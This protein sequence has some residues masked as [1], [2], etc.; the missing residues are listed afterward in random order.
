MLVNTSQLDEITDEALKEKEK[1]IKVYARV[2]PEQK[3]RIVKTLQQ[4]GEFVAMTGDGVND[5]PALQS[6]DIGIAMGIT[7]TDVSK[8]AADMILLDDNFSTIVKAVKEGRHIFDNIR[9]FIRY[10]MTGNAG[11]V[12]TIFLAPFFGLPVPLLPIHILWVNLVTDGLPGLTF[13]AEKSEKGIM[14]RPPRPTTESIFANGMGWQILWAG[15]LMGIVCIITQI[16][17]ME[18]NSSHAQT[19]VFTVLCF[20][21]LGNAM[22]VRSE[23]E[24]VFTLGPMSNRLMFYA[25]AITVGL[26]LAIIYVPFLNKIFKTQP[27][28]LNE[29]IITILLSSVIFIAIEIEKLIR[30]WKKL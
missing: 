21:Q 10:V 25:L 9:K 4:Q 14:Q 15:F 7:G 8:E 2:T 11:E 20:S 24:S 1:H 19:M 18:N 6:A 30:R 16:I 29:L 22:A 27:L 17:S 23:R 13:T 28:S 5:A 26:Q 12:W 3:L